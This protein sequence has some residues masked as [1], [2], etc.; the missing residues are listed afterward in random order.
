LQQGA[1]RQPTTASL[2]VAA[3]RGDVE[4]QKALEMIQRREGQLYPPVVQKR[5]DALSKGFDAQPIVKT[6]QKQAEAA[7]F[8][9]SLDINTK[10]PADDQALIYAFAKAM[11][12]DS[13]VRE[14]EYATVQHYAQ[15]WAERFGFDV[16]RIFS[17]TA[18]LTPQARENMKTTIR[19]K[20]AAGLSQYNNVRSEYARRISRATGHPDG[21][22]EL[23]DYGAV[24]PALDGGNGKKPF[25]EENQ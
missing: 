11:D 12:P 13:V 2:A 24:F 25:F 22:D 6:V 17:N 16:K 5:V 7:S 10:N 18:F 3:A 1:N 19:S 21:A 9:G 20:Y 23:I 8:A 4:A 15:S 14:G